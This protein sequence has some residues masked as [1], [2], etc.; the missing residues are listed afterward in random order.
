MRR[1]SSWKLHGRQRPA[2]TLA[3]AT[4]R[5]G[6]AGFAQQLRD[7]L[8]LPDNEATARRP[9]LRGRAL[10]AGKRIEVLP[11]V[12][13]GRQVKAAGVPPGMPARLR[14]GHRAS[15]VFRSAPGQKSLPVCALDEWQDNSPPAGAPPGCS[16]MPGNIRVVAQHA[17]SRRFWRSSPLDDV[18]PQISCARPRPHDLEDGDQGEMMR[19][20]EMARGS[21]ASR[22]RRYSFART[23]RQAP[24][25][26]WLKGYLAQDHVCGLLRVRRRSAGQRAHARRSHRGHGQAVGLSNYASEPCSGLTRYTRGEFRLRPGHRHRCTQSADGQTLEHA[27]PGCR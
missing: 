13:I 5:A 26:L 27:W 19:S 23:Q 6:N 20:T 14:S 17:S 15:F 3:S 16:A 2:G 12:S 21:A 18:G 1:R 8:K 11:G 7:Q 25:T 4:T 9:S 24:R 10:A 22:K